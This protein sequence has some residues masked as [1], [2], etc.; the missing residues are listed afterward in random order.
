MAKTRPILRLHQEDLCQAFGLPPTAKYQNEGGPTPE[1]IAALLREHSSRPREDVATFVGAL[2]FNW[3]IAGT[4]G[5]AKNYSLLHGRGGRVRLAPLYD[6]ASALPYEQMPL[7][8]LRLA[9]KVGGTYRL[10]DIGGYRWRRLAAGC[11]LD[12]DATL[13]Q[14]AELASRVVQSAG[15]IRDRCLA[16]GLSHPVLDRLAAAVTDRAARCLQVIRGGG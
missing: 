1:A 14:L 12:A 5:H 3:L 10:R 13:A 9:M 11:R 4:D 8:R 7:Q 16:S 6:L 2:A 15:V